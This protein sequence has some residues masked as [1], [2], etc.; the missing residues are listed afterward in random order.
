MGMQK[1]LYFI[2]LLQFCILYTHPTIIDGGTLIHAICQAL[3]LVFVLF[4]FFQS[5]QK[6]YLLYYIL[7]VY[8]GLYTEK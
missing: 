2:F 8:T 3:S 5:L 6:Q 4:F 7:I 1:Y